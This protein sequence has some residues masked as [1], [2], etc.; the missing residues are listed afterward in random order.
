MLGYIIKR[1]LLLI[2]TVIAVVLIAYLLSKWMPSNS[3]EVMTNHEG[4]ILDTPRGRQIY[5]QNYKKLGLD[6]PNFYFNI[7]PSNYPQNLNVYADPIEKQFIL[8][9]LEYGLNAQYLNQFLELQTIMNLINKDSIK[10]VDDLELLQ[11]LSKTKNLNTLVQIKNKS[12][13]DQMPPNIQSAWQAFAQHLNVDKYKFYPPKFHWNGLDNQFHNQWYQALYGNFGFSYRDGK[14][15]FLKITK[16]MKWTIMISLLS[17]VAIIIIS[18][19]IGLFTGIN[20]G[21]KLDHTI[22]F[23]LLLIYSIPSFWLA[24]MLI[25]F[26]TS[27]RY[28]FW[29]NIFPSPGNW[30]IEDESWLNI[31]NKFS[32]QLVLPILC[33]IANDIAQMGRI[34]RDNLIETKHQPYYLLAKSKGLSTMVLIKNHLLPNVWTP[35]I[36]AIAGKIPTLISGSLL[37]EVIFNIPGMGRMLYTSL[38]S[39]DWN[40]VLVILVIVS[41]F[42]FVCMFIADLLYVRTNPKIK[43]REDV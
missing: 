27:D 5:L 37:I 19:P 30:F 23:V 15:V 35:I 33:L 14:P 31:I 42:T 39:Q 4:V 29:M 43:L 6:K 38:D 2:P 9:G 21:S 3:A 26:F 8:M 10:N 28:G 22:H 20:N 32:G 1:S 40:V 25:N 16:A 17:V 7:Q 24:A 12:F 18:L 11:V 36:S 13:S 34:I 41:I